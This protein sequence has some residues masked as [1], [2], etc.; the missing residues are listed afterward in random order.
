MRGE[1]LLSGLG[2]LNTFAGMI[3]T[4][5]VQPESV[6]CILKGSAAD[7][8]DERKGTFPE[9]R[10]RIRSNLEGL[11]V[12]L[13]L[14]NVR[15]FKSFRKRWSQE[16]SKRLCLHHVGYSRS[17]CGSIEMGRRRCAGSS[18]KRGPVR[19]VICRKWEQGVGSIIGRIIEK[20]C[21]KCEGISW[22]SFLAMLSSVCFKTVETTDRSDRT[23][24]IEKRTGRVVRAR[25]IYYHGLMSWLIWRANLGNRRAMRF[26][27]PCI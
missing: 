5:F 19:R 20:T 21:R 2:K 15:Q 16:V 23:M 6:E 14:R 10:W 22:L 24:L 17:C 3:S 27:K 9:S 12:K 26:T 4:S 25:W 13:I 11:E 8:E 1:G 18:N 7:P